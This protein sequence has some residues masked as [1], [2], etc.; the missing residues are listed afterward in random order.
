[1]DFLHTWMRKAFNFAYK[2]G[3]Y[4]KNLSFQFSIKA[5]P[6]GEAEAKKLFQALR[7]VGVSSFFNSGQNAG[8]NGVLYEPYYEVK[9]DGLTRE[10]YTRVKDFLRAADNLSGETPNFADRLLDKGLLFG[11]QAKGGLGLDSI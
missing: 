2:H 9:A 5:T 6:E 7:E 8:P 3:L 11:A 10:Q 1:M 4:D